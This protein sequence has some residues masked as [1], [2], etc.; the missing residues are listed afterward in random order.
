MSINYDTEQRHSMSPGDLKVCLR[1]GG[2]LYEIGHLFSYSLTSAVE[3]VPLL[4]F[5]N[6][7]AIA[8]NKG[9]RSH[10]GTLIFNV[11]NY[12]LIH[13]LKEILTETDNPVIQNGGFSSKIENGTFMDVDFEEELGDMVTVNTDTDNINATDLPEFDIIITSQDPIIPTRY[14]QKKIIGIVIYGQSSAIGLDTVTTQ[15]AYPFMCK[16]VTPWTTFESESTDLNEATNE[17]LNEENEGNFIS[18][19]QF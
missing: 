11:I 18:S 10:Q 6:K 2:I 7:Y 16:S 1:V 14:S 13:E 19:F 15:D 5:G 4:V 8:E 12:S 9:K 17:L 3:S